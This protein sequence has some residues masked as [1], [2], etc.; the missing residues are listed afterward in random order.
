MFQMNSGLLKES[1]EINLKFL[2]FWNE[3]KHITHWNIEGK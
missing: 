1:Q 3:N 2:E